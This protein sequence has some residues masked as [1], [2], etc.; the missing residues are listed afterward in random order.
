MRVRATLTEAETEA[1][2]KYL[3]ESSPAPHATRKLRK[4]DQD[5]PTK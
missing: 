1:V 3:A 5:A 4:T 2:L